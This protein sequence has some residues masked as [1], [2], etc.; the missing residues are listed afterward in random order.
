MRA[1]EVDGLRGGEVGAA[2][3]VR[4]DV[5]RAIAH[6]VVEEQEAAAVDA[7]RAAESREG[8]LELPRVAAP[9]RVFAR[10]VELARGNRPRRV[11]AARLV[12]D[13]FVREA[14]AIDREDAETAAFQTDREGPRLREHRINE[15][16]RK[17]RR[18][19][20]G[21]CGRRQRLRPRG[22]RAA[23]RHVGRRDRAR[24]GNRRNR[25]LRNRRRS[26]CVR[27]AGL[28]D[29]RARVVRQHRRLRAFDLGSRRLATLALR[30]LRRS[31]DS[32]PDRGGDLQ[33]I[34]VPL[35]RVVAGVADRV[36]FG[37]E[38]RITVVRRRVRDAALDPGLRIEQEEIV[39]ARLRRVGRDHD[40]GGTPVDLLLRVAVVREARPLAGFQLERPDVRDARRIEADHRE[41]RAVGR[42][43]RRSQLADLRARGIVRAATA[44]DPE[45]R[46]RADAIS[47][48]RVTRRVLV[49]QDPQDVAAPLSRD[50][51]DP[52]LADRR[53]R[54]VE[55][56]ERV[57]ART[58]VLDE[59]AL[60]K[61]VARIDEPEVRL[62]GDRLDAA[63]DHRVAVGRDDE[64]VRIAPRRFHF[65]EVG[66]LL[67]RREVLL[68]I[69]ALQPVFPLRLH[70]VRRVAGHA[71]Q[72]LVE[73]QHAIAPHRRRIVRLIVDGARARAERPA[74]SAHA[75]R[76]REDV[77]QL[78]LPVGL[79]EEVA[80]S[81]PELVGEDE[82]TL[83]VGEERRERVAAIRIGIGDEVAEVFF[84]LAV[85]AA[86]RR[87]VL[88]E[89]LDEPERH[90]LQRRSV[91][92]C[93][94]RD[95]VHLL[96][97]ELVNHLVQRHVPEAR[98][99]APIRGRHP[100]IF[101]ARHAER[102]L[103]DLEDVRLLEL[104]VRVV[105]DVGDLDR[106]LVVE[107]LRQP[108]ILLFDRGGGAL[109]RVLL[110]LV[111]VEAQPRA[112]RLVLRREEID[113]FPVELVPA[114][115]VL[116][117]RLR[118]DD[119]LLG[120]GEHR[121]RGQKSRSEQRRETRGHGDHR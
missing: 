43:H 74:P 67:R 14:R 36:A 95:R 69:A 51:D 76:R 59:L 3:S 42:E 77:L 93:F 88:R 97:R 40:P 4:R 39:G 115:L 19:D 55:I 119:R 31:D 83:L 100:K 80:A 47:V 120:K 45:V 6:A 24:R 71:L 29:E 96:D 75:I 70:L 94:F 18:A 52:V 116:T 89:P 28:R 7:R 85:H 73:F 87:V 113:V 1:I 64:R 56:M 25:R 53:D 30:R 11:G 44:A 108:A 46:A 10:V 117:G 21:S 107:L 62:A 78:L 121:D 114:D 79:G 66:E 91:G 90:L 22:A 98:V 48:L 15:A 12:G 20:E 86:G 17:I 57:D 68:V 41:L 23:G 37:R 82:R 110:A 102:R 60:R 27:D 16:G 49:V 101:G 111:V 50:V 72:Q 106:R 38:S 34:D 54:P 9:D 13:R 81:L 26:R 112:L 63:I 92:P 58:S 35:V 118:Q 65:L 109:G 32:G 84:R 33:Q 105:E 103:A 8:L 99:I 2:E 61:R 5:D 104:A